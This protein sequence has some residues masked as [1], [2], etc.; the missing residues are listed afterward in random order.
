MSDKVR[1]ILLGAAA[2]PA[3]IGWQLSNRGLDD[4]SAAVA[5]AQ[6]AAQAV[7]DAAAS[8]VQALAAAPA[9]ASPAAAAPAVAVTTAASA[10]TDAL[11]GVQSGLDAM[12]GR[13]TPARV[14]LGLSFLLV[15]GSFIAFGIFDISVAT[16]G[17]GSP[18]PTTTTPA[19]AG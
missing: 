13:L 3:L 16:S 14:Y 10:L 12:T 11:G 7:Q 18:A 17:S 4:V 2:V 9:N 15:V 6:E 5:P 1:V 19:P 8:N